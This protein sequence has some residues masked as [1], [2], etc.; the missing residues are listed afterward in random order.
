M[1][2]FGAEEIQAAYRNILAQLQNFVDVNGSIDLQKISS[3]KFKDKCDASLFELLLSYMIKAESISPGSPDI[4]IGKLLSQDSTD[5][6]A[7]AFNRDSL[8]Q[9]LSTFAKDREK[10]LIHDALTTAGLHGK[11]IL[12]PNLTN[13]EQDLVELNTGSFFTD[14]QPVFNLKS[15]KFFDP[16]ILCIDGFIESVS[17]IHRVLQDASQSKETIIMFLRGLSDEVIH[18]LKANYDRG[19]L[20]VIPVIVKYD[21][22]GANLL[23]DIATAAGGDVVSSLKGQLISLIDISSCPRARVV[24]ITS[25]GVLMENDEA[26]AVVDQHIRNLQEKIL[27][28]S[29][30]AAKEIISRRIQSLGTRRVTIRLRDTQNKAQRT[31]MIDRCLRAVKSAASFGIGRWNNRCY[32]LASIKAGQEYSKKFASSILDLG[33]VIAHPAAET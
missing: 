13:G 31:F 23:N 27:E 26:S 29:V 3:L 11:I 9:L 10:S 19:T 12:S 4:I 16:R 14:V 18:T 5:S 33:A 22:E 20:A 30:E 2:I 32:P 7:L 8:D 17:E 6:S 15:T 28:S 25:S 24:D 1:Q 21:L